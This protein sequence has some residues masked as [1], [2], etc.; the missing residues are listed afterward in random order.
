[1]GFDLLK[2]YIH[3]TAEPWLFSLSPLEF[4]GYRVLPHGP[5]LC[6]REVQQNF[7]VL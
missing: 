6:S 4:C 1:M 5:G 7:T 3:S 2:K